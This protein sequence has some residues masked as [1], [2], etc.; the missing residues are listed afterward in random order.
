MRGYVMAAAMVAAAAGAASGQVVDGTINPGDGYGAARAVQTVETQ[1]GDNG[2]E[3]NAAYARV[4][5]GRLYLML[6]GNLEANFNKL[7]IFIDSGQPGGQ[8]VIDGGMNPNNDNWAAKYSGFTF[9]N[10]FSANYMLIMRQ[11]NGGTQFDVDYAVVG[12]AAGDGGMVGTFNPTMG[13]ATLM[14][15][16]GAA[17]LVDIDIAMNNSNAAGILGGTG[18]ADQMAAL[19]VTTGLEFSI[20]LSAIGNPMG[21]FRVSVMIN[22]SNHDYLSNQFL[23]GLMAPQGNLGGDGIGGFNGSVGQINLNNFAGDQ[24]FTIPAPGGAGALLAAGVLALRRRR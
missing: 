11:G 4:S 19:A 1:F 7:N 3:L 10:G 2:S 13:P 22:G 9:D 20:P 23:G 6:T 18:P 15:T 14:N 16:I 8:N 12:G 21:E 17:G 5:G 24:Y